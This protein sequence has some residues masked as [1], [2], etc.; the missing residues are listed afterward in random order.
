MTAPSTPS[1][2]VELDR[3][4]QR[5]DLI[6]VLDA[7]A[8]G[9]WAPFLRPLEEDAFP[10][11]VISETTLPPAIASRLPVYRVGYLSEPE[12]TT[13]LTE[14]F[15]TL[16]PRP[17]LARLAQ[18]SLDG[19]ATLAQAA[20]TFDTLDR[21]L[22]DGRVPDRSTDPFALLVSLRAVCRAVLGLSSLPISAIARTLIRARDA[23]E[24]LRAAVP[25]SAAEAR[26][27]LVLFLARLRRG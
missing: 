6:H 4:V 10:V 7:A 1:R 26:N 19:V 8:V 24:F 23:M 17:L 16:R 15:P 11:V 25:P 2:S 13:V 21:C 12:V 9:D 22:S 27:Q 20:E 5:R 18:G 14:H 3:A